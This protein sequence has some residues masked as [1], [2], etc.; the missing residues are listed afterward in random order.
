M[1]PKSKLLVLAGIHGNQD[2]KLGD[3]D[4]NLL[5][6]YQRQIDY[7]MGKNVKK[8]PPLKIK[9]DIEDKNIVNHK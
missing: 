2:G 4:L 8:T 3:P 5:K 6:D 1:Q 9:Q 7:F